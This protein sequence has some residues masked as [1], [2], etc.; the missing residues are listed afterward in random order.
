MRR[1]VTRARSGSGWAGGGPSALPLPAAAV[2]STALAS[3]GASSIAL[4]ACGMVSQVT[5]RGT[6]ASSRRHSASVSNSAWTAMHTGGGS[7]ASRSAATAASRVSPVETMSSSSTGVRAGPG[8][9]VGHRHLDLAVA[10]ALL[11]HHGPGRI[12]ELRNLGHPLLAFGVGTDDEGVGDVLAQPAGDQRRGTHRL[13]PD[14]VEIGQGM[15]AM[16]MRVHRHQEVERARQQARIAARRH[17]FAGIEAAVLPHVGQVGRHQPH[18]RRAELARGVGGKDQGQGLFVRM[19]Q[20]AGEHHAASP[21]GGV[22]A[23]QRLAVG[24]AVQRQLAPV[25]AQLGGRRAASGPAPGKA[26]IS[27]GAFPSSILDHVHGVGLRRRVLRGI[28]QCTR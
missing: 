23:H 7:P 19:V 22:Q 4:V 2:A 16:Q 3:S 18:L 14:R 8:A 9:A 12:G 17:G 27:I 25:A 10:V 15:P 20:A 28:G 24:K 26:K 11:V 1:A 21:H 5:T 6:P 13:G